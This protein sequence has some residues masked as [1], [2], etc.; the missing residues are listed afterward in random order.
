MT[1]IRELLP[2]DLVSLPGQSATFIA[3]APHPVWPRLMLVIWRLDDGTW[4]L[5][6]LRADQ[7]A[8]EA[9]RLQAA[10]VARLEA[11]QRW[12]RLRA[13]FY[14]DGEERRGGLAHRGPGD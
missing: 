8:G 7:E 1:T 14:G 13:A 4:S 6:A 9:A 12:A 5:D 3:A 10:D 2:G 11:E